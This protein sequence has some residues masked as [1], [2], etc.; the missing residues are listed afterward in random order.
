VHQSSQESLVTAAWPE[1]QLDRASGG[2][3]Q[4][5]ELVQA[6]IRVGRNL[7]AEVGL[8]PAQKAPF[9]VV[10]DDEATRDAW[11]SLQ[12][13]ASL[14][15]RAESLEVL[16]KKDQGTISRAIA[17]VATG[18]TVYLLLEGLVDLDRERERL[19]K[20]V[21]DALREQQGIEA[22]LSNPNFVERAP[23]D[24]VEKA[25]QSLDESVARLGRLREREASL[26]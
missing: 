23:Q 14:L 26:Q 7:R 11:N 19:A 21:A 24:V 12:D 18:G 9:V 17:G 20:A 2:A 3:A 25:R 15:L 6:M 5:V 8:N 22:R 10:A 13:E 1:Q 16:L 4:A